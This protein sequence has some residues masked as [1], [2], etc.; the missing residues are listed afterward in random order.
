MGEKLSDFLFPPREVTAKAEIESA[1]EDGQ[2]TVHTMVLSS[3]VVTITKVSNRWSCLSGLSDSRSKFSLKNMPWYRNVKGKSK[4]D[5]SPIVFR[6]Q[7]FYNLKENKVNMFKHFCLSW[8]IIIISSYG[9]QNFN[10]CVED[11]I[12]W[13]QTKWTFFLF[14]LSWFCVV[15]RLKPVS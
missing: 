14:L 4:P 5:T 7:C 10:G 1:T 9:L 6:L 11:I 15:L 13:P 3:N 8:H 2:C 12:I